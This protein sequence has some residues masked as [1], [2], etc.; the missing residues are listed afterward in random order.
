MKLVNNDNRYNLKN[1][2]GITMI[3]LMVTVVILIILAGIAVSSMNTGGANQVKGDKANLAK[4][5]NSVN[6][7]IDK[8][9]NNLGQADPAITA[10]F[11]KT[12]SKIMI[13]NIHIIKILQMKLLLHI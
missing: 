13:S 9:Y 4:T 11:D 5:E 2:K 10:D 8:L 6:N 12:T 7:D 1:E 3:T